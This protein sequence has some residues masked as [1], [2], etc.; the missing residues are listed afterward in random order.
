MKFDKTILLNVSLLF[1]V[2]NFLVGCTLKDE[3]TGFLLV[4]MG[5]TLNQNT[6]IY[7]ID[8]KTDEQLSKYF[9]N[10]NYQ[11]VRFPTIKNQSLY[12]LAQNVNSNYY[13]IIEIRGNQVLEVFKSN[14]KI[15]S[16]TIEPN[17]KIV[18]IQE[19]N[20]KL[21]LFSKHIKNDHITRLYEGGIDEKS[22]PIIDS[23]GSIIFA[24]IDNKI[25]NIKRVRHNGAIEQLMN[26]RYPLLMNAGADLIYYKSRSIMKYNL[27]KRKE[28]R[29]KS[30]ITLLETPVLSPDEKY[31]AFYETDFV[32][33][34]GGEWT[35]FL[36]VLSLNSRQKKH[37]KAYNKARITLN[38]RGI[39]WVDSLNH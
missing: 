28:K 33:P 30:K 12:C 5:T 1:I 24:A 35:D 11:Y 8:L 25:F 27:L 32:S 38:L 6:G 16:Y 15:I 4:P 36:S 2:S 18:F 23:D 20:G 26:G 29:L 39:N 37:I 7:S 3:L 31:L 14:K 21:Y 22:R 17:E 13:A 19:E 34:L 9:W 10:E